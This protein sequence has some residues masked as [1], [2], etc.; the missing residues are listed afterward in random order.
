MRVIGYARLSSASEES[1]SIARQRE[2]ITAHA[3]KHDWELV[4]IIEDPNASASKLR[5]NRPG[6]TR[7]RQ[8]LASGQAEAVLVWRLDRIARSVV[9]YGTLLDEGLAIVSCTEQLDTTTPMGRAMAEVLQV[10]AG[11]EARTI[12][13]RISMS[14]DYLRR[15]NRFPGG[16]AP[17]GYRSAPHPSGTGRALEIEP[18]EAKLILE[19]VERVMH[20]ASMYSVILDWNA[21]GIPPKFGGK[22]WSVQALRG[23]LTGDALLGRVRTRGELVT[24]PDGLPVTVWPPI[25]TVEESLT[26]RRILAP[27]TLTTARRKASRLLSGVIVCHSCGLPLTV[28]KFTTKSRVAN[29][30]V[31]HGVKYT[32]SRRGSGV[33]CDRPVAIEAE[34]TDDYVTGQFLAVVGNW[35]VMKERLSAP[36]PVGLAE[37]ED[38]IQATSLAMAARDADIGELVERLTDLRQ[39]RAELEAAGTPVESTMV[40]TGL[41]FAETWHSYDDD[42]NARRALLRSAIARVVLLPAPTRGRWDSSR[43][44]IVWNH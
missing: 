28:Q 17:V 2:I 38:A 27:Q 33:A 12:S 40:E 8:Y 36:A 25:I 35:P 30:P 44:D 9:D 11:M 3:A 29:G 34:A 10:F 26:L 39:R 31:H 24:G 23:I 18:E 37:I 21:R 15:N 16:R 42:V 22:G 6:L 19:A 5:L 20:G 41:T 7:V 43:L 14:V 32:C 1:T 4:E 13:A